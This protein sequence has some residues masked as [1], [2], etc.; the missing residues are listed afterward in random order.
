M[1]GDSRAEFL[2]HAV[3]LFLAVVPA[4]SIVDL[5]QIDPTHRRAFPTQNRI[6]Q[7][8]RRLVSVEPGQNR[9]GIQAKGQG[10]PGLFAAIFK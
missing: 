3:R 10:L 6:D 1:L 8:C 2:E 9:P 7:I 5:D 4:R